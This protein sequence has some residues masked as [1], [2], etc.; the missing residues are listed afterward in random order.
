MNYEEL[1]KPWFAPPSSAFGIAWGILYPVIFLSFGYVFYMALKKQLPFMVVLPF[2][3]NLL[4]NFL[5]TPIQFGLESNLLAS[6]DVLLVVITLVWAMIAVYQYAPI[7]TYVQIPYLL[8]GLFAAILQ[9]SITWL[10]W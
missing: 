8:W 6:I 7:V 5:F 10:N 1:I 3:L 9:I 2:L 4:F